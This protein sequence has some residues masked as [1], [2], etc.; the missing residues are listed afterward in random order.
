MEFAGSRAFDK[1]PGSSRHLQKEHSN[2][3]MSIGAQKASNSLKKLPEALALLDE[4]HVG[5][6]VAQ[7]SAS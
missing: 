2:Q 1:P 6:L 7:R 3:S 4:K 5:Q